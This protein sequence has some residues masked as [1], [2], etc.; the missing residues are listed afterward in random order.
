MD[1][2]TRKMPTSSFDITEENGLEAALALAEFLGQR[3]EFEEHL[4]SCAGPFLADVL[5]VCLNENDQA[6][7]TERA[8]L[9]GASCE[10]EI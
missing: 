5:K 9:A 2:E 3:K 4:K 10:L 7:A 1:K 6:Q 8:A